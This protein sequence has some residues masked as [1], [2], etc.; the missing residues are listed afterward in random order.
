LNY[1]CDIALISIGGNDVLRSDFDAKGIEAD[2]RVVATKL[3]ESGAECHV[4]GLPNPMRTSPLPLLIKRAL[5]RRA[6][7]LNVALAKACRESDALFLHSWNREAVYAREFWHVDRMHPSPVGYE[8]LSQE[9]LRAMQLSAQ[10]KTLPLAHDENAPHRIVWLLLFGSIWF[11]RRSKD[12]LPRLMW[13]T[14]LELRDV[15]LRRKMN[16]FDEEVSPTAK[17]QSELLR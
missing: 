8:Y 1:G 16:F 2:V 6:W 11:I 17:N 5:A 12:L 7:A 15:L 14:V 10:E 3:R 4:M 13:L 9:S